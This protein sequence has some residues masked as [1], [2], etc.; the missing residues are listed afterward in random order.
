MSTQAGASTW[1]RAEVEDFLYSEASLLDRW[2]LDDWLKLFTEDCSYVVPTTDLP[3][4]DPR[5]D[6]VFIDDNL[7]RL[8]GRVRKLKS[9]G[10]HREVPRSR[11]R[12]VVTNVRIV[13]VVDGDAVV[14][15]SFI[16]YRF[17]NGNTEPFV[18]FYRHRLTRQDGRIMIRERRATL[19]I[20]NLRGQ[21]AV[22]IIL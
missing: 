10:A 17:K 6:M 15:S 5:K 4:G 9:R 7:I 14:E 22:S 18:G 13:D 11:V 21:G 19:D 8:E 1:Q 20:E 3:D 16:I 2:Q 12:H